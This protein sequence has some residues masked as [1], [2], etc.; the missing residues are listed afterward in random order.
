[1]N[2]HIAYC[3]STHCTPKFI[4]CYVSII[5]MKNPNCKKASKKYVFILD[6]IKITA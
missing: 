1:M 5:L 3:K 6:Y 2:G 4:K